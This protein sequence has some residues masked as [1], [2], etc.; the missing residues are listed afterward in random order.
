MI[1][2]LGV[3]AAVLMVAPLAARAGETEDPA[4]PADASAGQ[5]APSTEAQPVGSSNTLSVDQEDRGGQAADSLT[6][7]GKRLKV[8]A[9]FETEGHGYNNLDFRKLD[10]TSDQS[11]LDSDDK[12][13][14]AYTGVGLDLAYRIDDTAR[15][16]VSTSYRG[17]WGNDQSGDVSRFG[18]FLYF[19]SLYIQWSPKKGYAPMLRVGRQRFDIGGQGGA[20][21]FLLSDTVDMVRVDFPIPGVGS[22]ITVPIDV[23]GVSPENDDVNFLEYMGQAS[24]PAF[25]FRGD[26]MTRRHGAVLAIT[27]DKVPGLDVRAYGFYSQMGGA[28]SGSD[29]SYGGELGNFA[30]KDWVGNVGAR[31]AYTLF[32]MLTPFATFDASFGVDRKA[33]VAYDVD[34]NGFAWS[35]GL[36]FDKARSSRKELGAHA[37]LR[38]W[39]ATGPAFGKDGLQFSH[40]FVGMKGR[41]VGGL[42]ANRFLG[43]RPSAYVGTDGVTDS[44][45]ETNRRSAT[46][47][48]SLDGEVQLPG[49]VTVGAGYWFLQDKGVTFLDPKAVDTITPPYG[50]SRDEFRAESRLGKVL[51]HEV[52]ASVSLDLGEHVTLLVQGGVLVPGA[53][54]GQTIERAAGSALGSTDPVVAYDVSGGVRVGF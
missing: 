37:E 42:V 9:Y 18:G 19:D 48:V 20:R 51:G 41:Y 27:P 16:A 28:G 11:I 2:R 47:V 44:P 40:G 31:A 32:D 46:R 49:R 38:Y 30:D 39:D 52:D 21:E 4:V 29:I 50:Y 6:P 33:L 14:F 43:W 35:A 17:L 23:V 13:A 24:G 54:Q 7:G 3:L 26:R 8:N 5:A 15:I 53:F 10:E 36:T 12:N 25:T 45:Q 22:L 34:A 1:S